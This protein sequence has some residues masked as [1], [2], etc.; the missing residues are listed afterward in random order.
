ML[1]CGSGLL[2]EQGP[3]AFVFLVEERE[4]T[5][6]GGFVGCLLPGRGGGGARGVSAR[7]LSAQ[8]TG[9]GFEQVVGFPVVGFGVTET[10]FVLF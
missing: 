10:I 7:G 5:W 8:D 2:L 4:K 1:C 9:F 6:G 3:L